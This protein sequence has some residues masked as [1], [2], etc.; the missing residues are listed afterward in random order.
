VSAR[1]IFIVCVNSEKDVIATAIIVDIAYLHGMD[2]AVLSADS[3][4][5]GPRSLHNLLVLDSLANVS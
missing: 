5:Q 1:L 2:L 4:F 3:S